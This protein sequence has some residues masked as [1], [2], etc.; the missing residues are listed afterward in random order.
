MEKTITAAMF[1]VLA[2]G[3][4]EIDRGDHGPP[5][6]VPGASRE[7][8]PPAQLPDARNNVRNLLLNVIGT[9]QPDPGEVRIPIPTD[10]AMYEVI[11][12]KPGLPQLVPVAKNDAD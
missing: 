10:S 1:S 8:D 2:L 3:A 12:A 5:I 4:V 7:Q 6:S 9:R 11:V